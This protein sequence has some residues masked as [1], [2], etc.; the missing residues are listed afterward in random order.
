MGN[1]TGTL[2]RAQDSAQSRVSERCSDSRQRD[3]TDPED[4]TDPLSAARGLV[5]GV[6]IG[7]VIW[8]TALWAVL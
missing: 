5:S 6:A 3:L 4:H 7:S 1:I 2:Q 8:A